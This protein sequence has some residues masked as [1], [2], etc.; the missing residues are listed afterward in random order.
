MKDK[1]HGKAKTS[2]LATHATAQ[3]DNSVR[4]LKLSE[5]AKMLGVAV[6]TVKA[7]IGQKKIKT[8]SLGK[9]YYRIPYTELVSFT[10]HAKEVR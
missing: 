8:I 10:T 9:R 5:A 4:L 1:N 2:R 6:N 7:F 3:T